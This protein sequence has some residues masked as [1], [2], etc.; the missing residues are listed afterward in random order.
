MTIA[1]EQQ[2][3]KISFG[4]REKYILVIDFQT[5]LSQQSTSS[6][7]SFTRGQNLCMRSP[8][9]STMSVK[10]CIRKPVQLCD[11]KALNPQVSLVT[12]KH[13]YFT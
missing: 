2:H 3:D 9:T 11:F 8:P 6:A 1:C 4:Q 13:K 12:S 5:L 7:T 10:S